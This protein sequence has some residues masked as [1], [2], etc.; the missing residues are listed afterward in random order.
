MEQGRERELRYS[1][2]RAGIPGATKKPFSCRFWAER[3]EEMWY[4]ES[5]RHRS[6]RGACPNDSHRFAFEPSKVRVSCTTFCTF[7]VFWAHRFSL[8]AQKRIDAASFGQAPLSERC[9]IDS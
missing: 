7:L 8:W 1:T 4:Y 6:D 3:F 2:S 9:R 5:M